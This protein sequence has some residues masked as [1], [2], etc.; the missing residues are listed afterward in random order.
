M[1]RTTEQRKRQKKIE[2]MMTRQSIS[3][4]TDPKTKRRKNCDAL[5]ANNGK[6]V[7]KMTGYCVRIVDVEEMVS[8]TVCRYYFSLAQVKR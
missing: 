2:I 4:L 5:I 1:D 6:K 8:L 7:A 3:L